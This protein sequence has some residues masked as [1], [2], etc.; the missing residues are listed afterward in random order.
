M[1]VPTATRLE[2]RPALCADEWQ[3]R[4]Q[5]FSHRGGAARSWTTDRWEIE[6]F[7]MTDLCRGVQ[8][9]AK[10]A[11]AGRDIA[12]RLP[13]FVERSEASRQRKATGKR[14]PER[15]EDVVEAAPRTRWWRG[16]CM[17]MACMVPGASA[18]VL[19]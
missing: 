1:Y 8:S 7:E 13:L 5:A 6:L 2:L 11:M 17:S 16:I 15:R 18:A 3:T 9:A 19:D 4:R 10:P 14:W 12:G